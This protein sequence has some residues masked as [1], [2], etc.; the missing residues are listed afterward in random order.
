[1]E[2]QLEVLEQRGPDHFLAQDI[3]EAKTRIADLRFHPT[4]RE[5]ANA[6]ARLLDTILAAEH[7][8]T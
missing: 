3:A 5:K 6:L 7:P 1:M 4:D 2:S 8:Y